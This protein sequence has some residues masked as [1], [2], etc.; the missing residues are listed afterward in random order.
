MEELL[1]K[2]IDEAFSNCY[3]INVYNDITIQRTRKEFSG[4]YTINVFPWVKQIKKSPDEIATNIGNYLKTNYSYI[5]EFEVVK[6]F[7]NITLY[8]DVL[9]KEAFK[10]FNFS[11]RLKQRIL[12]EFCSPN[13]NKPLHLGHVR[14]M[15]LGESLYK[16]FSNADNEVIKVN[17]VNDRGIHI[18]KSMLAWKKWA[19][20]KIPETVNLKGD[21]FVGDYYV[22]FEKEY[23]VQVEQLV[24][25]GV[26]RELA[27]K[28]APL[29]IEAQQL[30][31]KWEEGDDEV[32]ELWQMMNRWV[33][34]GFEDTYK[35]LGIEFDKIYY[36]SETY[37]LGKK[38]VLDGLSKGIFYAK[39]DGSVWVDLKDYG[40]DEKLL[41]R[42]DGTSVYITQDIGT[43]ILRYNEYKP[44]KMIYV[45]G[46]EQN[47]HFQVLKLVLKKLGFEW[48][49]KI[50]HLSYG[51]VELPEGKMKSREGTVVDADDL[52]KELTAEAKELSLQSGKLKESTKEEF[53]Y[54]IKQ[55]ALSALKYFILKVDPEKNMIFNP[56]ESIDFDGNTGPFILYT[57]SRIRS[58]LRK[59]K[60]QNILLETA[61]SNYEFYNDKERELLKSLIEFQF[62][63]KEAVLTYSPAKI[64]N[65]VYSLA[66][67]YNQYYQHYPILK[68][69]NYLYRNFRLKLSEKIGEMIAFNLQLLGIKVIDK[70]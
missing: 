38:Y 39:S 42:S 55:I 3:S 65:Y 31:Q 19:N 14:N 62:V 68:E 9:Q 23:K 32:R 27:E 64:A 54:G 46:N 59:A 12:I 30:L 2:I 20:G 24:S 10:K 56:K 53:E 25:E 63:F 48:A 47:Y 35:S 5:K 66:K 49:D 8:N 16:I 44:D 43:A 6:G 22:M 51:M 36:E 28:S 45:V 4:D 18:C 13:T 7:L 11:V 34:E 50:H 1:K 15:L 21:K 41:L 57:Y 17:L 60:E 26:E 29:I 61:E 58:L 33:Y 70:M 37:E 69:E 67:E 52:I 40:L